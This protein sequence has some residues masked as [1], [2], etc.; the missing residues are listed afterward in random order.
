MGDKTAPTTLHY[1]WTSMAQLLTGVI[2]QKNTVMQCPNISPD[3]LQRSNVSPAGL[4]FN[5]SHLWWIGTP[6]PDSSDFSEGQQGSRRL[7]LD[8]RHRFKYSLSHESRFNFFIE[9]HRKWGYPFSTRVKLV[10]LCTVWVRGQFSEN[11]YWFIFAREKPH[12]FTYEIVSFC[13]SFRLF[14]KQL[15]NKEQLVPYWYN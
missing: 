4:V 3:Y 2:K 12:S 13:R 11:I 10:E 14:C 9:S 7:K 6:L 8:L 1:P 15:F 5:G